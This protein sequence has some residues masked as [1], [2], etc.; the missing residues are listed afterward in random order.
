MTVLSMSRMEIDRV[1]VLQDL[2]AERIRTREAAQLI[3]FF[4]CSESVMLAAH[5]RLIPKKRGKP[6][7]RSYAPIVRTEALALIK[8][9]HAGFGPT[10]AVE[11]LK[12]RHACFASRETLRKWLTGDGLWIDPTHRLPSVH[13]PRNRHERVGKLVE[14]DGRCATSSTHAAA[15]PYPLNEP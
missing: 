9:N 7:S 2:L 12:E 1:H 14:I 11:K 10:L 15:P 8:A 4:D 3:R 6:S 13:Q 5:R